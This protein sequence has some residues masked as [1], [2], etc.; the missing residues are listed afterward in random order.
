MPDI[1][2][3]IRESAAA[4]LALLGVGRANST[5]APATRGA[6]TP[7]TQKRLLALVFSP[8]DEEV[9]E[10]VGGN[11]RKHYER[12]EFDSL[13]MSIARITT[14]AAPRTHI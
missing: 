3:W 2:T 7:R 14:S 11:D 5:R 1:L 10:V 9:E 8:S 6:G 13:G 12:A 4:P